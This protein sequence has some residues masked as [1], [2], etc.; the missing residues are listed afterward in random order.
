M[1]AVHRRISLF[2]IPLLVMLK[3]DPFIPETTCRIQSLGWVHT[4]SIL[5]VPR[6]IR[7]Q[8]RRA[9]IGQN[10]ADV[11]FGLRLLYFWNVFVNQSLP[12]Y[13]S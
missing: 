12:P 8:S 1:G 4:T 10:G 7:C 5:A 3:K 2:C 6:W 13:G 11:L 9:P